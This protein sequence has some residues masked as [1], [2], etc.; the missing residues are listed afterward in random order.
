MSRLYEASSFGAEQVVKSDAAYKLIL[1]KAEQKKGLRLLKTI[2]EDEDEL[3]QAL[4]SHYSFVT[5]L[6]RGYASARSPAVVVDVSAP[7]TTLAAS[8]SSTGTTEKDI[9]QPP[10]AKR[11]KKQSANATNRR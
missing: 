5:A 4:G 10:P 11:R 2:S 8:S 3:K 9:M 6:L 7:S 1:W